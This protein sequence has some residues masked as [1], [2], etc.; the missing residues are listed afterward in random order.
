MPRQGSASE[1]H[2]QSDS[3]S[4]LTGQGSQGNTIPV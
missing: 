2:P 1:T 4:D 3:G